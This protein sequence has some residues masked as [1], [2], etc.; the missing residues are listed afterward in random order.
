MSQF[1]QTIN[2]RP[3]IGV[4]GEGFFTGPTISNTYTLNS[5]G[6]PNVVGAT[7]YT[8]LSDFVATAGGT[9]II[10]GILANPK[11]YATAGGP[12]GALSP[13]MTLPDEI[14]AEIIREHAGL[15]VT[16][17]PPVAAVAPGGD[18]YY[19]TATGAISIVPFGAAAPANSTKLVGAQTVRFT[20]AAGANLAI[21]RI[22]GQL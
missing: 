8:V 3:A 6:I 13:T 18:V 1:Q 9:G 4:P 22:S 14:Q 11:V 7:V 19:L 21:V 16:V 5:S 12:L 15:V 17:V 2:T 20:V 10:A